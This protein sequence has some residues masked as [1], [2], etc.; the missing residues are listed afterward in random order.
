MRPPEVPISGGPEKKSARK[1]EKAEKG[2]GVST[3]KQN[4]NADDP[5]W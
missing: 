2:K 1:R 5:A 4:L 3:L